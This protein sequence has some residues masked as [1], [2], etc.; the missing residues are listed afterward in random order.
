ML[1]SLQHTIDIKNFINIINN[2]NNNLDDL[3]SSQQ[4][5]RFIVIDGVIGAGKTTLINLLIKKYNR[6]NNIKVHP[7]FEP[8]D[9]WREVGALPEFYKCKRQYKNCR[10]H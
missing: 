6:I 4:V 7:I 8:V 1:P 5:K 2:R 3:N 10:Y 9:I